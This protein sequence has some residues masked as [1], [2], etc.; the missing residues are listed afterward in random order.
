MIRAVVFD[1]DGTLHDTEQVYHRAWRAAA[2]QTGVPRIMEFVAIC[3]GTN[4]ARTEQLW[5]DFYGDA[6]SFH[7]FWELRNA[8][9]DDLIDREG[10]PIKSGA[11]EL[12]DYLC[13]NGYKIALATSTNAKRVEKH[14]ILS[15]MK[16]YFDAVV[17]GDTVQR[18]KPAPDIFLIAAQQL[19]INPTDCMG[20]ED[21]FNGVRAVRAA[22]MY[23]VMAPDMIQPT[24]EILDL[25]DACVQ[26]LEQIIPIL[27]SMKGRK[28]V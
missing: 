20:V 19:G 8:I 12:L 17:T 21:S 27:E 14:L 18:G 10:L 2:E 7:P 9:Y 28:E 16:K 23:T 5:Q 13:D 4:F 15:D 22:G 1:K 6:F 3:T 25:T 26:D 24:Q 11:Y